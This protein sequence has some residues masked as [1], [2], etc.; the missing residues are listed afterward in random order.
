[1]AKALASIFYTDGKSLDVL[2][3]VA[4]IQ[5]MMVSGNATRWCVTVTKASN[6][7]TVWTNLTHVC[8][9]EPNP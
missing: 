7:D 5:A 8:R 3:T 2:E 1:M 9:I 4:Q 6:G